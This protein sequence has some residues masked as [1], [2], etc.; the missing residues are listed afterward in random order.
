[1]CFLLLTHGIFLFELH[2]GDLAHFIF[3]L[4]ILNYVIRAKAHTYREVQRTDVPVI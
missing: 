1:M 4:Y 2:A 3:P